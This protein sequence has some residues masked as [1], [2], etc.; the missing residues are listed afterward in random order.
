MGLLAGDQNGLFIAA[1]PPRHAEI[2]LLALV[3]SINPENTRG[4]LVSPFL[5]IPPLFLF[6]S[7]PSEAIS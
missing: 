3:D 1:E 7:L 6:L 4:M 5:S 2:H